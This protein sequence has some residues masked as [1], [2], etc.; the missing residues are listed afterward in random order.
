MKIKDLISVVIPCYNG[1]KYLEKCFDSLLN[2]TYKKLEI[3][4]ID[5][6]STDET[7]HIIL[8]YKS[9]FKAKGYI[10]KNIYQENSGQAAAVN[11]GLKY[12]TGEYLVWQDCD[13]Y[14]ENDALEAL[15]NYLNENKDIDFVRGKSLFRDDNDLNKIIGE[16]NSRF[17][18]E[19]NIFDFYVFETDSY[20]FPGIFMVRM[21]FLINV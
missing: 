14:Y 18:N 11:K 20:T 16:G 17:P 2:Q 6:G 7:N 4:I 15:Y 10:F 1:E 8:N 21:F 5:D 13:D 12:A 3:I 9:K 19:R